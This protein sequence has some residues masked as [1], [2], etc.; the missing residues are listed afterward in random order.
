M[1]R[2]SYKISIAGWTVDSSSDARTELVA[3]ET[4]TALNSPA[5]TCR[6]SVYAMP[7]AAAAGAEGLSAAAATASGLAGGAAGSSVSAQVRGQNVKH[8]DAMTIDLTAGDV[9]ARVMTAEVQAIHLSLGVLTVVGRTGMQRLAGA[10]VNQVYENQS[11]GPI[12]RDLAQQAGVQV[13]QVDDGGTHPY[14]V[15]HES[16]SVLGTIKTLAA[17][18][19]MDVYFDSDNKLSVRR[20]DR[21]GTAYTFRYGIDILDVWLASTQPPVDRV[22]VHG[23]SPASQR[24]MDTWHWLARD[25]GPFRG[26]SGQGAWTLAVHEGAARTRDAA[27]TAAS[28]RLGAIRDTSTVGQLIVLGHPRV[29][30]GDAI[31][32]ADSPPSGLNGDFKV[33]AVRHVFNKRTGFVTQIGFSARGGAPSPGAAGLGQLLAEVGV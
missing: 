32:I 16:K 27:T 9:S 1:Q 21:P 8:A 15:A 13:G 17:R 6:V 30:L 19:G 23:E 14:V 24:G 26:Q 11:V 25:L 5:N 2:V 7:G 33:Q 12:V 10:R 4:F 3:L 29:K 28:A 20:L 31:T 18:E 22:L